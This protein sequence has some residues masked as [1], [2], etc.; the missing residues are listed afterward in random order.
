REH[1]GRR[2]HIGDDAARFWPRIAITLR[3]PSQ[4]R[5]APQRER[6]CRLAWKREHRAV[7]QIVDRQRMA[8]LVAA[9]EPLGVENAVHLGRARGHRRVPRG[10]PACR[11]GEGV[12]AAAFEAGPVP[13]SQRGRL[14]E[15]EQLGIAVAPNRAMTLLE[16]RDAADPLAR[17]PAP[18]AE[19]AI[20][21]MEPAAAI[22]H[23]PSSGRDGDELSEW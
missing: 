20:I 19:R 9:V 5:F 17:G 8:T 23:E 11:K 21:A 10:G 7:G 13:G 18:R 2:E 15:K 1:A 22:A 3:P 12:A 14:V 16:L 4:Q 6:G